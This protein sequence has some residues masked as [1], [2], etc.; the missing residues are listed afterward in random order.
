LERFLHVFHEHCA[1]SHGFLDRAGGDEASSHRLAYRRGFGK[2]DECDAYFDESGLVAC[3]P[4]VF[5]G[6][7]AL[8]GCFCFSEQVDVAVVQFC[9]SFL[10]SFEFF[11]LPLRLLLCDS[12]LPKE[13]SLTP[14]L[15]HAF[16][17]SS[18]PTR[19]LSLKY[20]IY[21]MLERLFVH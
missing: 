4:E 13:K 16:I 3:A 7:N 5:D 8:C 19:L 18:S 6:V 14:K 10:C 9:Q 12:V 21:R 1:V 11:H 20:E 15:R 2:H 17:V